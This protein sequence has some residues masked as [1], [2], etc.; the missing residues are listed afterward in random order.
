LLFAY[1]S[2]FNL[3]LENVSPVKVLVYFFRLWNVISIYYYYYIFA[4]LVFEVRAYTLS[5]STSPF[6]GMVFKTVSGKLFAQA[7]FE[8]PCT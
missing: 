8:L 6:Y 7:G 5:H 1:L 3:L 2:I 4:V